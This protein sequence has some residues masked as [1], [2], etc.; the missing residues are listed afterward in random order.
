MECSHAWY[1][2][3]PVFAHPA[4][5]A[6]FLHIFWTDQ[7]VTSSSLLAALHLFP[8]NMPLKQ[9]ITPVVTLQQHWPSYRCWPFRRFS[10]RG[11]HDSEKLQQHAN[12]SWTLP[13]H[14]SHQKIMS[15]Y[16]CCIKCK[17]LHVTVCNLALW[18]PSKNFTIF[19][20]R[21]WGQFNQTYTRWTSFPIIH[22]I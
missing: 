21:L 17:I 3:L 16:F 10:H 19:P 11:Q 12:W 22:L 8:S 2:H 15:C 5:L 4:R 20:L 18:P 1:Y 7:A 9:C 13:W 6:A 14:W